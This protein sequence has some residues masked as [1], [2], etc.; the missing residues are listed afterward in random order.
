MKEN[1]ALRY[2]V[3]IGSI[4]PEGALKAI[5]SVN[6]NGAF[7]IRGIKLMEGQKG[8]FVSMPNYKT[9]R[10]EYIDICFPITAEA[11]NDLKNA[12]IEAYEITLTQGQKQK[13]EQSVEQEQ[14]SVPTMTM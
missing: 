1:N 2:D 14:N 4:K 3:K 12:V 11:R 8:L 7:A 9:Q 10:G 13:E 5:A 6:I